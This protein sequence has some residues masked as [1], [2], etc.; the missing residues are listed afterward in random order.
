MKKKLFM[1][2]SL[3]V[4]LAI[5]VS[6]GPNRDEVTETVVEEATEENK[7]D[8]LHVWVEDNEHNLA[9]YEEITQNF[10]EETGIDV[11][12]TPFGMFDQ[13]EAMSLDGPSGGGPDLFFQPHDETGNVY[14]QGLAAELDLTEEEKK[15]YLEGSMEA[16]NYEDAQIGIPS[17]VETYT[18]MYN[19]D[20]VPEVPETIEELEALGEHL[21]VPENDEYG[22]LMEAPEMYFSYPF[23]EAYGG[24][25]FEQEN[26]TSYDVED[27]GIDNAGSVQAGELL[28]S[29]YENGYLPRNLNADILNG[30]FVDGKV[31]AVFSG[32]WNI[33]EYESALGDSLATAPLPDLD[34][35]P[36]TSF[37]SVKGWMVNQYS[38]NIDWAKELALFMTS[39][40]SSEIYFE[41]T[42]E[43]PA[44]EDIEMDSDLYEA[45]MVQLEQS[46]FM[47]NIPAASAVWDPMRDAMIFISNGED[48]QE[49]LTETKEMIQDEIEIMGA[50]DA[51]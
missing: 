6:C 29:W 51:D 17:S 8:S 21:T 2:I 19:T 40:E 20:L 1:G 12:I 49:V 15:G 33:E 4:I 9:A 48:V 50:A 11:V 45:F 42:Q 35:E 38:E 7:P 39:E 14:L 13:L 37:S 26:E 28:Q 25:I 18:L 22:F 32:P 3:I 36:L 30:L 44:R 24:Y 34:G 27:I 47:P 43:I 10:T 23:F 31:G 46:E 41:H 5:L 16:L